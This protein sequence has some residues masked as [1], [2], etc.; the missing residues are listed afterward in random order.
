MSKLEAFYRYFGSVDDIVADYAVPTVHG[1]PTDSYGRPCDDFGS[2]FINNCGYDGAGKCLKHIFSSLAPRK[3]SLDANLRTFDQKPFVPYH[4]SLGL[5]S[6]SDQGF[7]YVPTACAN[8]AAC[9]VHFA[10]H[11]CEQGVEFVGDV[12]ARH[13][14]FNEWAEANNII[15]VYPQADK[16]TLNP[17]GCWDW[18]G[19]TGTAYASRVG[20]QTLALHNMFLALQGRK[21]DAEAPRM[22]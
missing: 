15:V 5:A 9:G 22:A 4:L 20:T 12:F 2:P 10:L 21:W 1:M 6:M 8:G 11:G 16:N 19:Y 18:W 14:G 3:A 17:N 13:S 7:L